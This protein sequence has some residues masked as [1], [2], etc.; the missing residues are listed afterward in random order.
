MTHG[1]NVFG[2]AG[3]LAH[4]FPLTPLCVAGLAILTR[5]PV[6]FVLFAFCW[7]NAL[8][9]GVAVYVFAV[10]ETGSET[11]ARRAAALT[12]LVPGAFALVMGYTE[13]LA[14]L[15][16][17]GY[18][19]AVRRNRTVWALAAGLLAGISR[20]TGVLLALPGLIETLRACHRADW[21]ARALVGGIVRTAAPLLGLGIYLAYCQS[22]FHD[23]LLPYSQQTAPANR[24]AVAQNPLHTLA[25]LTSHH[26]FGILVTSLAC[27][28]IS[29][30]GVVVCH[31]RL[32]ASDTAWSALMLVL[33]VTSPW[34]TSE[35]RYL[36]AIFPALIGLPMLLRGRR[37]WYTFLGADLCVLA[38]VCCLALGTRQVA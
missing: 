36:A 20:P 19:I 24:G 28:A 30:T 33:G 3:D 37:A 26:A 1:G 18:F 29:A 22:R 16:A 13:P 7:I 9:F 4:F 12:Q 35:P 6:T 2:A 10:R 27:A 14:D 21:G 32:A 5:L 15:L 17:I 8:L 38:W 11:T 34:F 25:E 31:R 23:W